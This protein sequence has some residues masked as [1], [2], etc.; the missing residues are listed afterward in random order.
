MVPGIQFVV[1]HQHRRSEFTIS[2]EAVVREA[3]VLSQRPR[4]AELNNLYRKVRQRLN[5]AGKE[6]VRALKLQWL[7]FRSNVKD[8]PVLYLK[9][10]KDQNKALK[11]LLLKPQ[12][13]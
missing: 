9:M 8:N 2:T 7:G 5:A 3:S 13:S 10:T 4:R 12:N 11:T 1:G 6:R